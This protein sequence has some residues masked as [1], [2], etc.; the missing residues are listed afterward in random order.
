MDLDSLTPV[1]HARR[2]AILL[3]SSVGTFV[4]IA[5]WMAL[6]WNFFVAVLIGVAV[7]T[8]AFYPLRAVSRLLFPPP[9]RTVRR[10]KK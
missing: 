7:G 3:A 8:L 1:D 6:E 9:R 2:Y 5:I 10:I 4:F